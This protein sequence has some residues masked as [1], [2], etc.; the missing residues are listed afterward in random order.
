MVARKKLGLIFSYDE[1]WIGGT[2]YIL[3]LVHALNRIPENDK[4]LITII[5][6]ISSYDIL[7]KETEYPFLNHLLVNNIKGYGFYKKLISKFTPFFRNDPIEYEFDMVFPNPKGDIFRKL[8]NKCY[9]IPDFQEVHLPEFFTLKDINARKKQQLEIARK[10]ERVILSSED[11]KSDYL[12]LYPDSKAKILV[13]PFA[14]THRNYLEIKLEE[15][16]TNFNLKE[17]Y[18]YCPNQFWLHKNHITVLKA[19]KEIKEKGYKIQVLFSGKDNDYRAPNLLDSLKKYVKEND[20]SDNVRFLGFIS[21]NI[22]LNLLNY[23]NAIIQPSIFEGWSTVIEDAKSFNKY[24]IAS[25]LEVHREQLKKNVAFFSRND[26]HDLAIKLIN[27]IDSSVEIE[28]EDYSINIKE[29][30][31][32]F[33]KFI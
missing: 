7:K 6:N 15:L 30:G 16:K 8:K 3:N 5:S 28:R 11:A 2:Y 4:P 17:S 23:S 24:V 22:M 19:I 12:K 1:N 25:D 27:F 10:E 26:S 13:L 14:V 20:L 31:L 9:W 18:F 32:R 33:N 29:V 21:R